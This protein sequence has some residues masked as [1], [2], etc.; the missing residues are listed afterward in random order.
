M[1][2]MPDEV[3]ALALLFAFFVGVAVG[4]LGTAWAASR[5]PRILVTCRH[6]HSDWERCPICRR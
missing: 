2:G 4:V 3:V 6:G 5:S 1:S